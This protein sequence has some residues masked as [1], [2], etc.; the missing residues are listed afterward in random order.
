M[1]LPTVISALHKS[2]LHE[3]D[4]YRAAAANDLLD[5]A[6]SCD[7][8]DDFMAAI[9]QREQKIV[10]EAVEGL[11]NTGTSPGELRGQQDALGK[12]QEAL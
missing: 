12:P 7:N 3:W 9:S 5:L 1:D 2:A 10:R 6:D 4:G 11:E 8:L